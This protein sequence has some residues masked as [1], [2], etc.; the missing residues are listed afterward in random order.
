[1]TVRCLRLVRRSGLQTCRSKRKR[2]GLSLREL[3]ALAG[4]LLAVFF[5][6]LHAA[7]AGEVAGVAQLLVHAD[8]GRIGGG[9]AGDGSEHDFESAGQSLADG[10]RLAGEP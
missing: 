1:M 5:A 7:V 4:A 9:V 10:A 8:G 3:E 2:F 6:L